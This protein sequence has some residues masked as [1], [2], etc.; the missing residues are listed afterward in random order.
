MAKLKLTAIA[1]ASVII[2]LLSQGTLAYYSTVGKAT[3][4]IT[5]GGVELQ[6]VETT[7]QGTPF[8]EEGVYVMPGDVV[9]KQVAV[10]N[11]CEHP[12]YLRV[13]IVYGIDSEVLPAEE[14]FKL[15]VNN[16]DWTFKDGWYYYN[17]ELNVGDT[18]PFI[19]SN[20]EIVGSK[21]DKSYIGKTLLLTVDAQAVQ[22]EHNPAPEGDTTLVLG[23]PAEQTG[24]NS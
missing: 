19:F 18:T 5:T 23:W 14:C 21:V 16:T 10:K 22:S 13:K 12:F 6:I 24:G 1:V 7:S 3:N 20:V 9:S 4:V 17:G 2:T 15:N 11:I 8:P